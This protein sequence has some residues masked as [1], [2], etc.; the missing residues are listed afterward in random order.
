MPRR[1]CR[2]M[3]LDLEVVGGQGAPDKRAADR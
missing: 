3:I 2:D 1:L